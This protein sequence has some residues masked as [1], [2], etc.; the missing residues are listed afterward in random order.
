MLYV[1][2]DGMY[3]FIGIGSSSKHASWRCWVLKAANAVRNWGK[4]I[5]GHG[6]YLPYIKQHISR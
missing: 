4:E 2:F 3:A 6:A 1:L 5:L